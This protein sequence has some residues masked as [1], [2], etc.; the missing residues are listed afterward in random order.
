MVNDQN[1]IHNQVE[2][3]TNQLQQTF[4]FI[5]ITLFVLFALTSTSLK[6]RMKEMA[7]YRGIGMTTNQLMMMVMQE[8]CCFFFFYF[9]RIVN[10]CMCIFRLSLSSK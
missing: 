3:A 4:E 9:N 8:N 6:K 7:L 5:I 1:E 2:K 10:R